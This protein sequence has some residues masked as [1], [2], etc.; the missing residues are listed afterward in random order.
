M[1]PTQK[2]SRGFEEQVSIRIAGSFLLLESTFSLLHVS[3]ASL[4]HKW[5]IYYISLQP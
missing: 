5:L 3:P 2:I 1:D 4:I